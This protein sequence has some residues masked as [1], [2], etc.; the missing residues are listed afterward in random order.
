[1]SEKVVRLNN[2][3]SHAKQNR[4]EEPAPK[5]KHL[6]F[7]LVVSILLFS[8]ASVSL[9]QSYKGL[10]KQVALEQ[11]AVK[12]SKQ[13]TK[14]TKQK[15]EEIQKLKDPNFI[16]KYARSRYNYSESGEK[17]FDTP[18]STVTGGLSK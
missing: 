18:D 9:V 2:D 17:I 3:F 15:S 11:V 12:Q 10:Q 14:D 7:I 13:L 4:K 6:G 16:L 5:R 8:L 1:M